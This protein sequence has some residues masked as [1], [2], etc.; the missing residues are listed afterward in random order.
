M[1]SESIYYRRRGWEINSVFPAI[2]AVNYGFATGSLEQPSM[3]KGQRVRV[4]VLAGTSLGWRE[5]VMRGIASYSHENG[6]WHVYTAPEGSEDSLFFTRSYAWDG[7]IARVTSRGLAKRIAA[8]G[9]PA[10]S[11]GSVRFPGCALPRVK[12]DDEALCVLALRHLLDMGLRRLA[13]CGLLVSQTK[14]DRAEAFA[15]LAAG[16][17]CAVSSY[18]DFTRLRPAVTWQARQRDLARWVRK[19]EKPVGVLAW[20]PDV[21][22]RVVEACHRAGV[23]VPDEVAVLGADEDRMKLELSS[24]SI[25]SVE[26]PSFRIG[27]EAAALLDRLMTGAS[28]PDGPVLIPPTGRINVR[29][30]TTLK[31]QAA[32]EVHKAVRFIQERSHDPVTVADVAEALAVSRRWLE[33]HFRQVLGHSPH[34]EIR[35]ARVEQAKKLLIETNWATSKVARSAGFTSAPYLNAVF[36]RETGL[37]PGAFRRR[38]RFA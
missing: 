26:F 21:A 12:V 37:T 1:T 38:F 4:A 18:A 36:L 29:E 6:P 13:Y 7:L 15:R 27:Y 2:R 8:L 11:I 17:G 32:A 31:D 10:V 16:A 25:S 9:V 20:N 3:K 28:A 34:E 30:S 19:L 24:P 23:A 33:R 5:N 22:C 14:E 35:R